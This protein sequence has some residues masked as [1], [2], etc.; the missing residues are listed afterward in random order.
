MQCQKKRK[1]VLAMIKVQALMSKI[2][3]QMQELQS[4]NLEM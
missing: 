1:E 4:K 3:M 2:D